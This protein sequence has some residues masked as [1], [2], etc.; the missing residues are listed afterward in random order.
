[1]PLSS[2]SRCSSICSSSTGR[3]TSCGPR[4]IRT[5]RL[6]GPVRSSSLRRHLAG[7]RKTIGARSYMTRLPAC[8]GSR[9]DPAEKTVS[10]SLHRGRDPPE[11]HTAYSCRVSGAR[12]VASCPHL[13]LNLEILQNRPVKPTRSRATINKKESLRSFL[14]LSCNDNVSRDKNSLEEYLPQ[15]AFFRCAPKAL[16]A[17]ITACVVSC[18]D[19]FIGRYLGTSVRSFT[20]PRRNA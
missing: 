5:R 8:T 4:T 3:T 7:S 11:C 15:A 18:G 17:T 2:M 9:I 13:F 20:Y 1:M 10:S 14:V 12:H 19:T 6:S 16:T